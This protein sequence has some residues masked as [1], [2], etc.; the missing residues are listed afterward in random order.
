MPLPA[1]LL[2]TVLA[3]E[4]LHDFTR[5]FTATGGKAYFINLFLKRR[6]HKR[7][8]H[9]QVKNKQAFL[10]NQSKL[11][12]SRALI[13]AWGTLFHDINSIYP[14]RERFYPR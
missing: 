11:S 14:V 13:R 1:D 6:L 5:E 12:F 2:K 9:V 8:R 4:E 7:L 10:C 3:L